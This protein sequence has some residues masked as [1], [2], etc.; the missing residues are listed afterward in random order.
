MAR[1]PFAKWGPIAENATQPRIVPTQVILHTAVDA[2]G[3]TDLHGYFNRDDVKVE[4][5]FF[6]Q[7]DG[8]LCQYLDTTRRAD[9]QYSANGRAISIETEDD[10]TLAPWTV[11]QIRTIKRL[12]D[13]LMREHKGILR[14]VAPAHDL[15]GWGYHSLFSE[16]NRS[17]HSCPG[18]P[19]IHQFQTDLTMWLRGAPARVEE[20]IMASLADVE[21]MFRK[22][23]NEGT[24]KGQTTWSGTSAATLATAQ[25][26]YN[27][28]NQTLAAVR[29]Q[30]LDVEELATRIASKLDPENVSA[31]LVE[32]ALRD[33]LGSLDEE[34]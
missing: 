27:K 34:S 33:V 5:H 21:K 20:E 13:Y 24:G 8:D 10:G 31:A 28:A 14:R 19:R 15:P 26:T 3:E 4:S 2:P 17:N 1:V 22:V 16:W 9:A 25:S 6:V 11:E 32:K 29:A 12:G 23:L 30:S 7:L 18:G